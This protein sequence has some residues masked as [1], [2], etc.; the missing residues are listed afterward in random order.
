MTFATCTGTTAE[1]FPSFPDRKQPGNSAVSTASK[2]AMV[3]AKKRDDGMTILWKVI[4]GPGLPAATIT[5]RM[6]AASLRRVT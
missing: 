3:D 2:A 4:Y 6:P 1:P 5:E